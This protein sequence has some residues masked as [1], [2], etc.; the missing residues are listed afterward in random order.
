[1]T[2]GIRLPSYRKK[3]WFLRCAIAHSSKVCNANHRILILIYSFS[4]AYNILL[5]RIQHVGTIAN[6][7]GEKDIAAPL[8]QVDYP[9]VKFWF[10]CNW[11]E[12]SSRKLTQ[13]N[14]GATSTSQPLR[15]KSHA[16]QN[17]NVTMRYIETMDGNVVD[18]NR[19]AEMRKFARTIWVAYAKEGITLLSW[20]QADVKARRIYYSKMGSRFPELRLCEL[21]WKAEQI[22]TDNYP[23]WH[24]N[25][26]AKQRQIEHLK[27]ED[28]ASSMGDCGIAQSKCSRKGSTMAVSKRAK[29]E[30]A[31][32]E[33]DKDK[34]VEV[35]EV[36]VNTM[37][38]VR[39]SVSDIQ[40]FY[41]DISWICLQVNPWNTALPN[42]TS[43]SL[44]TASQEPIATAI[45]GGV[46][47]VTVVRTS[48]SNIQLFYCDISWIYLQVDPGNTAPPNITSGP[49]AIA[50]QEPAATA[51]AGGMPG[52]D[53]DIGPKLDAGPV[54]IVPSVLGSCSQAS[55]S[56]MGDTL[57]PDITSNTPGQV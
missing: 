53:S 25:W 10:K 34:G 9:N 36:G 1:M 40:L 56:M 6:E 41:H 12:F 15:G 37:A 38:V 51:I 19:A 26:L 33:A 8:N 47:T 21:D 3:T 23:S 22:A 4:E 14:L 32:V 31:N 16:A 55:L 30:R 54:G 5:N 13:A 57:I 48:V 50:F 42:I 17:I 35:T 27:Q 7:S 29:I 18:G 45:A 24:T 46:N 44:A 28:N 20:G 2:C 49:P 43:G 39:V 52:S 11:M